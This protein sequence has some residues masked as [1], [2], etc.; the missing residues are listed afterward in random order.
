LERTLNQASS[1]LRIASVT[2]PQTSN[3]V[4]LHQELGAIFL[5]LSAQDDLFIFPTE[6]LYQRIA[7]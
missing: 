5:V 1:S 4:T 6:A 2:T 3:L 7:I